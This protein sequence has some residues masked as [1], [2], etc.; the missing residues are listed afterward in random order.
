MRYMGRHVSPRAKGRGARRFRRALP[1]ALALLM[2]MAAVAWADHTVSLQF[3]LSSDA[4][5]TAITSVTE[6]NDVDV[7]FQTNRS[8]GNAKLF[9][10]F[11]RDA[12]GNT[13]SE[14]GPVVACGIQ[15]AEDPAL[16]SGRWVELATAAGTASTTHVFDT[17]GLA[18]YVVGFL[19]QHS[20]LNHDEGVALVTANLTISQQPADGD[21]HPGCQ[22]IENAY[23]RVTGNNGA[24][25]SKGKGAE[26]LERVAQRLGCDLSG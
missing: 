7:I 19:V 25:Q 23:E 18:G 4:T 1:L 16:P 2:A 15:N 21:G 10:C 26:A 12:D 3:A 17:S 5:K 14:P 13:L 20:P 24:S 9:Q 8:M 22:G 6:G 11:L